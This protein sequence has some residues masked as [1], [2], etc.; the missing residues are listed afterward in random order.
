VN[1]TWYAGNREAAKDG[2]VKYVPAE[3]GAINLTASDGVV[4]HQTGLVGAFVIEPQGATVKLDANTRASATITN[5]DGSKFREFVLVAQ[6]DAQTD[7]DGPTPALNYRTEPV[8]P[9]DDTAD[10]SAAFSNTSVAPSASSFS[11]F[12]QTPVFAAEKQTKVRFRLLYPGGLKGQGMVNVFEVHGHQWQETPY[13]NN[14][15]SLGDNPQSQVLGL[16]QIVPNDKLDLLLASAG[17]SA[18]VLGDYKFGSFINDFAGLWGIMRVTDTGK[19]ALVIQSA[20]PAAS[21]PAGIQVA[22][23]NT[24]VP[25]TGQYASTV[26]ILVAGKIIGTTP[27]RRDGTWVAR[28]AIPGASLT[29]ITARSVLSPG[30][31]GGQYTASFPYPP[32]PAAAPV[33]PKTVMTTMTRMAQPPP[34]RGGVRTSAKKP[35]EN[36]Q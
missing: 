33:K 21:G 34:R 28:I 10:V 25:S 23:V 12:P 13:T 15:T 2:T 17:G 36:T 30:K 7:S 3:F 27:V 8:A 31:F 26:Q 19:D 18:G 9:S 6:D 1:L 16:Q 29:E 22:G 24:V 4:Q 5:K 20:I 11:P 35:K 32:K 14:S